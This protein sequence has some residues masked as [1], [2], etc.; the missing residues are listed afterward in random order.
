[1]GLDAALELSADG[2]AMTLETGDHEEAV[3]AFKEKRNPVFTDK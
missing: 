1:M 3:A 2:E